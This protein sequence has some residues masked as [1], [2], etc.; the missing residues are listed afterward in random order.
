[1]ALTLSIDHQVLDGA[2]GAAFLAD[3]KTLV[4]EP[5]RMVRDRTPPGDPAPSVS[6][7]PSAPHSKLLKLPRRPDPRQTRAASPTP[8]AAK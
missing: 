3:L 5:M 7:E 2:S 4:E 1:M 8:G 6:A